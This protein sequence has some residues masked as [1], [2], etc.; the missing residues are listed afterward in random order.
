M[1]GRC[2]VMIAFISTETLVHV[3]K[4]ESLEHALLKKASVPMGTG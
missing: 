3:N 2:A 1:I 4:F